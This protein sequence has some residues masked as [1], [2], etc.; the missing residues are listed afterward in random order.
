M[1]SHAANAEDVVLHRALC[2]GGVVGRYVDVG[3]SSPYLGS[4]TRHFYEAGWKGIDVEPLA[5]EAA[6]LRR[7]RPRDVVIEAALGSAAGEVTLYVVGDERGLSSTDAEVGAGYVRAGRP[8]RERKV[9][10]VTLA[11]VLDEHCDG[12][13]TFLKVDVEGAE[14]EVL[15]GNDW[16]RWRPRV[17]VVEATDPWSYQQT[18][19][20]WEP[21]L[22]AAGYLFASFD[23]INRF[24][25]RSEEPDLLTRLA[26]ASVLDNFVSENLNRVEGYVR[27]LE[28]ELKARSAHVSQLETF[29]AAQEEIIHARDSRIADLEARVRPRTLPGGGRRAR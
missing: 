7:A 6:E 19:A 22:L 24:Y 27:H 25:A 20:R 23:G 13:I 16:S 4:V 5:E 10:Q 9:R 21:Q 14:P 1:V 28:A 29:V 18:H 12:E 15:S 11:E 2:I 8:V 26:P 17:V 3:A